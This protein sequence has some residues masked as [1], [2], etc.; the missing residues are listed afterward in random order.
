M[1]QFWALPNAKWFVYN[2]KMF[3]KLYG[4]PDA[5]VYCL[6]TKK[7]IVFKPQTAKVTVSQ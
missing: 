1:T 3:L 4:G 5:A 7:I 6:S 2:G